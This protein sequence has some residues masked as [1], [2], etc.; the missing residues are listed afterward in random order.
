MSGAQVNEKSGCRL[1]L[2]QVGG[3]KNRGGVSPSRRGVSPNRRGVPQIE[4]GFPQEGFPQ[5]EKGFRRLL[6]TYEGCRK[7]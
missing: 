2:R 1:I 5:M 3:S 4:E 7:S 6:S